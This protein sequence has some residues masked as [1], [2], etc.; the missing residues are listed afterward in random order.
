MA[1]IDIKD[2]IK[3]EEIVQDYIRNIKEIRARK[4][5]EKVR[6]IS[7]RQDLAK[8]FQ[9]VVQATEKSAS[10][11]TK[12]LKNLKEEPEPTSQ[13][14]ENYFNRFGNRSIDQY[15]TIYK[16]NG[17]YRIGS[18]EVEIGDSNKIHIDNGGDT[19]KGTLR[20]YELMMLKTPTETSGW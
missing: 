19:F 4:E 8:V 7:Q 10:Q 6:D 16:E 1:F 20:L 12:V 18:K 15:F 11:I 5:N 2:P 9:L 17:V 13:L 14:V 3:R